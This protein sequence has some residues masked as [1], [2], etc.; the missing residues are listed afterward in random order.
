VGVKLPT[1]VWI[2]AGVLAGVAG[3][4]NAVG[5]LGFEHQAVTHMTV[6]STLLAVTAVHGDIHAVWQLLGVIVG[7]VVGAVLSGM[8][9]QDSTLRL[10]RRYGVTLAIESLMLFATVPLFRYQPWLG[11][12]MAAMACGLQNAMATTFSGALVRTTHLT[13]M[14][15]DL[16]IGL[17]HALRRMPL[18]RRRLW[19]ST[20]IICGFLAGGA[21]GALLFF[22]M[23]YAALY[24]PATL[25]GLVGVGYTLYRH[26]H[27][28]PR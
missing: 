5:F 19:L 20:L 17:G 26:R 1:W 11:A 3:M 4:V 23:G 21:I 18:S 15:T 6:T 2:G 12:V 10:G 27:P 14:F 8:I 9:I 25:T 16:G 7:F 13:G 22:R 24:L 28:L